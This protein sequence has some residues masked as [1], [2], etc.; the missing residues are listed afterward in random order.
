MRARSSLVVALLCGMALAGCAAQPKRP[1]LALGPNPSAIIAADIA[2]SRAASDR[3]LWTAFRETMDAEAQM[4]VP[5]RVRAADF[6]KG[7]AD[8]AK[9]PRWTPT[10]VVTSCD[11]S[12]GV[13]RGSAVQADGSPGSYL[14][15]WTRMRDGSYRWIMDGLDNPAASIAASDMIAS[16]TAACTGTPGMPITAPDVGEDLQIGAARDQSLLWR[17]LVRADG[18]VEITILLWNGSGFDPV[19]TAS[20]APGSGG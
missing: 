15:V 17:S 20:M 8:P 10:S 3:G 4:F 14:T 5:Q 7:R 16:R 19:M 6:V 1:K 12:A 9:A 13:T 18:G 11:G 2:F